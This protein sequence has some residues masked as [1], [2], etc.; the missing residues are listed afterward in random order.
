MP[1][2]CREHTE[3]ERE[4]ETKSTAHLGNPWMTSCSERWP[5]KSDSTSNKSVPPKVEAKDLR[6][7]SVLAV[8]LL[9]SGPLSSSRG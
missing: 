2:E 5:V 3:R 1:T 9:V 8:G 4:R 6:N 7:A